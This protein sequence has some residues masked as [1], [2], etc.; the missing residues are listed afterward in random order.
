MSWSYT[1]VWQIK[2]RSDILAAEVPREERQVPA[3]HQAPSPGLQCQK[4][5][6]PQPL[7]VKTRGTVAE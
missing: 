1:Q 3:P 2:I 5:K 4:A 7:A 6:S